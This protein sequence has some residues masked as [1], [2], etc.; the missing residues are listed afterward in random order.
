MRK[1]LRVVVLIELAA[2]ASCAAEESFT[3][4]EELRH[5]TYRSCDVIDANYPR[6]RSK[7]QEEVELAPRHRSYRRGLSQLP[8]WAEEDDK[9]TFDHTITW[10]RRRISA[11]RLLKEMC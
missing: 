11:V 6:E 3:F 4:I 2:A 8:H 7:G 10:L 5:R 1:P 9:T